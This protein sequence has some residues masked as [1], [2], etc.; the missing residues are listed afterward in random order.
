VSL[1][2]RPIVIP[3]RHAFDVE[4]YTAGTY[5]D[6]GMVRQDYDYSYVPTIYFRGTI[7]W[8]WHGKVDR[9]YS[10]G[11]RRKYESFYLDHSLL[12]VILVHFV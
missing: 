11:I 10:R 7:D 4:A 2:D 8:M 12:R 9:K 5:D 3:P 6:S 1:F